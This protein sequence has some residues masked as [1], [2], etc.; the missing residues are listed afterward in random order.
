MSN[1]HLIRP[2][3]AILFV[4]TTLGL[5][6]SAHADGYYYAPK[7]YY[8]APPLVYDFYPI[9]R[10]APIVIY[11]PVPAP[12]P[13]ATGYYYP[14]PGPVGR[15]RETWNASPHRARYRYEYEFPNGVEYKYR[16]KRDGGYVRFSEK[17]DH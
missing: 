10:P 11:E 8:V 2:F 3:A 14:L 16:Y 1:H 17:W 13:P 6:R 15:A 5:S 9:Y 4:A 7:S 12:P